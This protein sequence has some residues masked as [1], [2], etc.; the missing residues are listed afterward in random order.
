MRRHSSAEFLKNKDLSTLHGSEP[1]QSGQ[2]TL[3]S[4][5]PALP[6]IDSTAALWEAD[7]NVGVEFDAVE[8]LGLYSL[9]Y[10]HYRLF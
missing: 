7:Q 10:A 3:G 9:S 6:I 5:G 8:S 1:R 4:A 2:Q